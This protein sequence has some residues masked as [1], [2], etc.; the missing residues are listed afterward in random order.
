MDTAQMVHPSGAVSQW[1]GYVATMR[2]PRYFKVMLDQAVGLFLGGEPVAAR[3]ILRDVVSAT[4]G[5]EAMAV[6]TRTSVRSLRAMLTAN[7]RLGMDSL[8][9]IFRV[10]RDWLQ[11]AQDVRSVAPDQHFRIALE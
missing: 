8:S 10:V 6:S 5:F 9:I 11:A 7:G 4:V 1:T 3:L 2:D